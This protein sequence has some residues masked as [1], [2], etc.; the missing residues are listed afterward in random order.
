[1]GKDDLSQMKLDL[2]KSITSI[3]LRSTQVSCAHV[4]S[5]H[6]VGCFSLLCTSD[7]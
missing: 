4:L 1:M 7:S 6:W 2:F 3:F 5:L